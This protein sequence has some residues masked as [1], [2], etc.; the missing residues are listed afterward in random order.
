VASRQ[1][2]NRQVV[3]HHDADYH[4]CLLT[5]QGNTERLKT[6]SLLS[7]QISDDS[8]GHQSICHCYPLTIEHRTIGVLK[9][10]FQPSVVDWPTSDKACF[11]SIAEPISITIYRLKLFQKLQSDSLQDPLTKLFIRRY[12]M[13]ILT[14]LLQR[15]SYGNYQ[16]GLIMM[17][18]DHF[19]RLNDTF[20][21]VRK[22]RLCG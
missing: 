13:S 6:L 18:I 17:D 5:Q 3:C 22:T 11:T 19:K 10:Y 16:V 9:L 12:M 21:H 1:L 4:V 14:K 20:G 2:E 15:V 8:L 7:K